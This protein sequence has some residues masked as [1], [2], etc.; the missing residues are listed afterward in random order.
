[1]NEQA[2]LIQ[3][4]GVRRPTASEAS[5]LRPIDLMYLAMQEAEIKLQPSP[6]RPVT[7]RL[8]Q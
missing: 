6:A 3:A 1:M 8:S 2:K 4:I 7:D 5:K